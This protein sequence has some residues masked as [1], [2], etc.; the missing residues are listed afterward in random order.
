MTTHFCPH[1]GFNLETDAPIERDGWT[2]S[3]GEVRHNGRVVKLTVCERGFLYTLARAAG[4]PVKPTTIAARISLTPNYD[5]PNLAYV[6]AKR[7]R[8][9]LPHPPFET[10]FKS[11]YR[12]A[13]AA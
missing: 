9:R 6:M 11:G 12:W 8:R 3:L 7:I 4:R 5:D 10:V 2:V 1:C 13:V